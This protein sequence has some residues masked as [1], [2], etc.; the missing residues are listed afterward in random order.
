[1]QHSVQGRCLPQKIC[2][3]CGA[4]PD[5]KPVPNEHDKNCLI[6]VPINKMPVWRL[7]WQ[8]QQSGVAPFGIPKHPEHATKVYMMGVACAAK[9]QVRQVPA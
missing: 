9:L 5:T 2:K 1:M 7:G 6:N 3:F 4:G 8:M